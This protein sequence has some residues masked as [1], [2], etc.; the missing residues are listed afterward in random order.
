MAEDSLEILISYLSS[1]GV[2]INVTPH[3]C[4]MFSSW[5]SLWYFQDLDSFKFCFYSWDILVKSMCAFSSTIIFLVFFFECRCLYNFYSV[6]NGAFHEIAVDSQ[7]L[8]S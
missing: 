8:L 5:K 6:V 4:S 1:S 7:H 3:L 2:G